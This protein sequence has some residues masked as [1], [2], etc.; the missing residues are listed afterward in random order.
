MSGMGGL[1]L[2][3]PEV[4]ARFVSAL[5]YELAL[6]VLLGGL[7]ALVVWLLQRRTAPP[8]A[9]AEPPWRRSLRLGFGAL[10]VAAGLLQLQPAMP[11]GLSE[12]VV[13]PTVASAPTWLAGLVGTAADAW[14]RH[15]ILGA[16]GVVWVELGLGVALIAARSGWPS[17]AAATAS[18]AFA[19]VVLV[20]GSGF[21]GLFVAPYAFVF[22]APGA[23]ALYLAASVAIAMSTGEPPARPR[24][25]R[26]GPIGLG[27]ALLA[28][29]ATQVASTGGFFEGGDSSS[30]SAMAGEM[31]QLAQPAP[32]AAIERWFASASKGIGPLLNI[33]IVIVLS[34]TGV[35][36]IARSGAILRRL[37]WVFVAMAASVWLLVQD[38]GVAGGVATDLNSMPAWVL[39]VLAASQAI[40]GDGAGG[41]RVVEASWRRPVASAAAVSV[42]MGGALMLGVAVL[43]GA[44]ADAALA[45]S[46]GVRPLSGPAP[47]FT[48]TDQRGRRVSLGSLRPKVVV[49]VFLDPVCTSECPIQAQELRLAARRMGSPTDVAFV[50]VNANP[51]YS[52]PA[53][54][55]A[56][57]DAEGL[58]GWR[59]LHFLTGSATE[60]RRVWS[61]YG[62]SV[63][64]I[65]PGGM[66][67][68]AE[69]IFIIGREGQLVSTWQL[70]SGESPGSVEGQST[71]SQVVAEVERAR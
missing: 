63:S 44:T 70:G 51:H 58:A 60:L 38:L 32:M 25:G 10:W 48:L 3:S 27:V 30:F 31:A 11:I 66:E 47:G 55:R 49:L 17:R 16:S 71:V 65:G 64:R 2:R 45:I 6:L 28:M 18:A 37:R 23:S 7:A 9:S 14:L 43:P 13:R 61:D 15:P 56:F 42:L 12:S 46:G 4:T 26:L 22:G 29:A 39:L 67:L 8:P 50:A 36:L 59:Q 19:A 33:V 5:G 53:S 35:A 1:R 40:E 34:S 20:L 52:S 21:G 41:R 24:W 68:H 62:V 57:I 54:S 69:P